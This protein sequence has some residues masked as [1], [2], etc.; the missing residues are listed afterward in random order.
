MLV[1]IY[2]LTNS[3]DGKQY[4][5][6][7]RRIPRHRVGGLGAWARKKIA[8]GY[9]SSPIGTAIVTH[10]TKAFQCVTLQ[11]VDV[12]D[13]D[14]AERYWI[15]RLGTLEP[16]GYNCA[17]G[18]RRNFHMSQEAKRRLVTPLLRMSRAHNA[19]GEK[20]IKARLTESQVREIRRRYAAGGILQRELGDEY[21]I[22]QVA[23]SN[24]I[25]RRNW[26]HV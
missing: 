9:R 22:C 20:N 7:T 3:V 24:I 17:S 5:G 13:A 14:E 6:Q 4:V 16:N 19:T 1:S 25:L 26:P 2:L 23:I 21:G 11:I 8:G 12:C 10:G 18:G 15:Q